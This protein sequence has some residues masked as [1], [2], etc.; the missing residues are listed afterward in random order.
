VFLISLT[1]ISAVPLTGLRFFASL[2]KWS[3][4]SG[5]LRPPTM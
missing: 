2:S 5:S 4:P 1:S 3:H